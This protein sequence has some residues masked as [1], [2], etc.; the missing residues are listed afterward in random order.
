M[1]HGFDGKRVD[2]KP[3][4]DSVRGVKEIERVDKVGEGVDPGLSRGLCPARHIAIGLGVVGNR[5]KSEI[6][7]FING[8]SEI[9]IEIE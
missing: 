6:Q 1:L 2:F 3:G 5:G 8:K 4:P 7:E 9:E